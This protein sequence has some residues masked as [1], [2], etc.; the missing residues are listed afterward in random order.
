MF[1]ASEQPAQ[2]NLK[3]ILKDQKLFN[4]RFMQLYITAFAIWATK[5]MRKGGGGF[6]N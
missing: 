4:K 5:L 1:S 2:E 3:S 6:L